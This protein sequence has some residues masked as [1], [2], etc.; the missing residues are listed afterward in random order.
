MASTDTLDDLDT[1]INY[2]HRDAWERTRNIIG[3]VADNVAYSNFK[4]QF[5]TAI[6]NNSKWKNRSRITNSKRVNI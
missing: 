4:R 3:D 1:S 2:Y 6:V 5:E